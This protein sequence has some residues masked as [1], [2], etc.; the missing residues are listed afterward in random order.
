MDGC[1]EFHLFHAPRLF[2]LPAIDVKQ[3][4]WTEDYGFE[5][6]LKPELKRL[7]D[8][9]NKSC[10]QVNFEEFSKN[11]VQRLPGVCFYQQHEAN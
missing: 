3:G 1:S 11:A 6:E 7:M 9:G 2:T 10:Q 5:E 4:S 8:P